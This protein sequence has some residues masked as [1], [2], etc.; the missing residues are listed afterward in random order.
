MLLFLGMPVAAALIAGAIGRWWGLF[1]PLT[2][3]IFFCVGFYF[4]WWGNGYDPGDVWP[5]T[6]IVIFTMTGAFLGLWG[7]WVLFPDR[8]D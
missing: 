2:L 7:S 3:V 4:E 6:G 5:L 1:V 8:L